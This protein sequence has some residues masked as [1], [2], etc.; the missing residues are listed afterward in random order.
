MV[1]YSL[2]SGK[3]PKKTKVKRLKK[4]PTGY[5]NK[6]YRD[7]GDLFDKYFDSNFQPD[8]ISN[9]SSEDVKNYF[10]AT[11]DFGEGM[12]D[13]INMYPTRDR[14]NNMSF[15]FC[16]K[17]VLLSL[18]RVTYTLQKHDPIT[19][20]I[21]R[22]KIP[23]ELVFKDI[24]TFDAQ[25][26]II[27]SW[28]KELDIG[29]KD[30]ASTLTKKAPNSVDIKIQSKHE[31]LKNNKNNFNSVFWPPPPP[32]PHQGPPLSPPPSP[33]LPTNFST[34]PRPTP[35]TQLL[36]PPQNFSQPVIPSAPPLSPPPPYSFPR[37]T[38]NANTTWATKSG[39]AVLEKSEQKLVREIEEDVPS[40]YLRHQHLSLQMK[41]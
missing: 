39:E 31:A 3:L 27:G 11:S 28:L 8:V 32:P 24:S 21:F 34:R 2:P 17:L 29:K 14:L 9:A 30:I 33:P 4:I 25:N 40:M 10:L 38:T 41:Y 36:S 37:G 23:F 19:K 16:L 22:R 18:S 20:N 26:F 35:L 5:E 15:R 13:D 6:F 1:F 12:Q 7:L